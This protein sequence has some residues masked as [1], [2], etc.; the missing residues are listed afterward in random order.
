MA[1]QHE[2]FTLPYSKEIASPAN[3]INKK[4][5]NEVFNM[6]IHPY[7][8]P[9]SQDISNQ[10]IN[11]VKLAQ[12]N[13]LSQNDLKGICESA[14]INQNENVSQM[15]KDLARYANNY[16]IEACTMDITLLKDGGYANTHLQCNPDYPKMEKVLKLAIDLYAKANHINLNEINQTA[17]LSPSK[18]N[19][20]TKMINDLGHNYQAQGKTQKAIET[21]KH[22]LKLDK[23]FGSDNL[24]CD[25]DDLY[26]YDKSTAFLKEAQSVYRQ[27]VNEDEHSILIQVGFICDYR[28]LENIDE[29]LGDFKEADQMKKIIAKINKEFPPG[30]TY[31]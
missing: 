24:V 29:K 15:A 23:E 27:V 5:V 25:I 8:N 20:L 9:S 1:N 31:D 21:Y 17:Y 10:P 26:K 6:E 30:N 13:G 22:A 4:L 18:I 19:N 3:A 14:N 12:E 7:I 16:P 11:I 2:S 28:K